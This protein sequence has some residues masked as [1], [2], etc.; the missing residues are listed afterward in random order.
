MTRAALDY[1]TKPSYS[2]G[3]TARDNRGGS[4]TSTVAVAVTNVE[5]QGTVTLNPG[6]AVGG[7][8]AGRPLLPTP[9]EG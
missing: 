3:V 4:D 7:D 9:T 2:V 6:Q 1:E 5:E 8:G